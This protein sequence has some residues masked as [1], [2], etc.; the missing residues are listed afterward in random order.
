MEGKEMAEGV[1]MRSNRLRYHKTRAKIFYNRAEGALNQKMLPNGFALKFETAALYFYQASV[2]FRA[3]SKWREAGDALCRCAS[4]Y[5]IRLK[6][7]AEA[8]ALYTE[9]SEA[10]SKV[11][12]TDTMKCLTHAISIY[13]DLGIF[14]VAGRLQ[15]HVADLHQSMKHYEEAA[16]GYRKAADFLSSVPGQ[17]DLCLEKAAYC[18]IECG[19][20]Q[21]ASDL[22]VLLAESC[23]QSNLKFFQSKFHLFHAILCQLA[24]KVT[25]QD[26]SVTDE[27]YENKYASIRTNIL[28]YESIDPTW[29]CSKQA[30]FLMN[31][32]NVREA[33]DQHGFADH[34]YFYFTVYGLSNHEIAMLRV[35][36]DEIVSELERRVEERKKEIFYATKKQRMKAKLLKKRRQLRERGLNPFTI[37]MEDIVDSDEEDGEGDREGDRREG[38]GGEGDEDEDNRSL[39]SSMSSS[40]DGSDSESGES[41]DS[42]SAASD[43]E[44][45]EELKEKTEKPA[46]RRRRGDPKPTA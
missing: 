29:R 34:V 7:F 46:P 14:P 21:M 20:H 9:A 23:I 19:E 1:D 5:Q 32:I 37:R 8:A 15:R 30:L 24:I 12:N 17:S 3:A 40:S 41:S 10:Y 42:S 43:I 13:C 45:P 18:L 38:Q 2:S 44:L 11:D 16:E 39:D 31:L 35:V 22:F 26:G 28:S 4:L 6:S 25:G 33:Y 27:D 36:S